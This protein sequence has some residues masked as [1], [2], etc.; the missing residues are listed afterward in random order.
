V[1]FKGSLSAYYHTPVRDLFV[2]ALCVTGI[3][4]MTYFGGERRTFNFWVTM[5]AGLAVIGVAFLPTGRPDPE[6]IDP[7]QLQVAFGEEAVA[8][9]HFI[10]AGIFIL[11]LAAICFFAFARHEQ[12]HGHTARAKVHRTCGLLILAA[13]AWV[14]IGQVIDVHLLGFTPLYVGEAVSVYAFGVSWLVM[15]QDTPEEGNAH[16][17]S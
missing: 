8:T 11:S 1:D 13:V 4:L 7:T 9:L 3:A 17:A 16:A 12:G 15:A 2:G 5:V 14:G 6:V 10:C